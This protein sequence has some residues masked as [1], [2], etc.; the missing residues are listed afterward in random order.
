MERAPHH[1]LT[2]WSRSYAAD[3]IDEPLRGL[4]DCAA[5]W[6]DAAGAP[7][8]RG[9]RGGAETMRTL[10]RERPNGIGANRC[11]LYLRCVCS[12]KGAEAS[13]AMKTR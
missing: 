11:A 5:R 10:V 9:S 4:P 13:G 3:A 8:W 7:D 2:P 12:A 6:G 1:L